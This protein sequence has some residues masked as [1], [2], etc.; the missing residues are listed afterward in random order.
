EKAAKVHDL[1]RGR[2]GIVDVEFLV[3]A[4]QLIHGRDQPSILTQNVAYGLE[5]LREA[6]ILP[7]IEGEALFHS[8]QFL[9]WVEL[10]LSLVT[11]K[12]E[13]LGSL[14]PEELEL[15]TQR[16]GYQPTETEA[17]SEILGSE[18]DYHRRVIRRSLE[19]YVQPES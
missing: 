16:I 11:R 5:K 7:P 15:A 19:R 2:G 18:L 13:R 3:Q 14:S 8:Y 12:D 4:L 6:D 10:R 9:R 1:K 17:A